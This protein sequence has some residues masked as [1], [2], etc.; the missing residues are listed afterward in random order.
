MGA[1]EELAR[2]YNAGLT[3]VEIGEALGIDDGKVRYIIS[4]L[5]RDGAAIPHHRCG[6][7][8]DADIPRKGRRCLKAI[9]RG[10]LVADLAESYGVS[11]RTLY[12]WMERAKRGDAE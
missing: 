10:A 5:R 6:K 11:E 9:G 1:V 3:S 7:P 2:L 4:R 12:R 8:K